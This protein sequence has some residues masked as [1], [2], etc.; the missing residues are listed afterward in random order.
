M[1]APQTYELGR[2]DLD[3]RPFRDGATATVVDDE[4]VTVLSVRSWTEPDA[5][6]TGPVK[7]VAVDGDIDLDTVLLLREVLV[8]ALNSRATV[9]CDLSRVTFFGAAAANLLLAMDR[10][11]AETVQHFFVR[12]AGAMTEFVL[13]VVDPGRTVARS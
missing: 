4:G 11:T 9:C 6:E 13:A 2:I 10:D 8:H 1:T 7:V 12:G 3:E 5:N